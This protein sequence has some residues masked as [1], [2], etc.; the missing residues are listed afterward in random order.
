MI[1]PICDKAFE[2]DESTHLP[3]CSKR[4]RWVDLSKWL[5]GEYVVPGRS[6][7]LPDDDVDDLH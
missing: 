4:C 1:C 6:A 3:F 2:K 7:T 5:G